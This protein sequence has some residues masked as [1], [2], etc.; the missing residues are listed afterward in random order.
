MWTDGPRRASA[1]FGW[2]ATGDAEGAGDAIAQHSES[3]G[4]RATAF[5][6]EVAAIEN[7]V[8]R[9]SNNVQ[10]WRALVI[11]SDSTSAIAR[12]GH[13]GA[14]PGQGRARRIHTWVARLNA[15][16]SRRTVDIRW[17]KGH[18]GTP[19]NERVDQLAGEAAEKVG[20]YASFSLAFVKER[21]SERFRIA[22]DQWHADPRHHGTMEIPPPP[23]KKSMLDKT[24]N[25]ISRVA[26][27]IRAGHY[28]EIGGQPYISGG[29][30]N[31]ATLRKIAGSVTPP[32]R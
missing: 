17:T 13:T 19:G 24:R 14:G 18:V 11:H 29:Y 22:R 9:A 27:Q 7:A 23:P 16:S 15:M 10:Q 4:T 21:I 30:A 32:L 12:A 20:P 8:G 25:A 6:A 31:P 3:I 2:I 26:A 28:R 5:D 1:G